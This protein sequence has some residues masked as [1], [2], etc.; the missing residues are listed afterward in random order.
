MYAHGGHAFF[1]YRI[2]LYGCPGN[3]SVIVFV[4]KGISKWLVNYL[5]T[6]ILFLLYT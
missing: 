2:V 5:E 3:K 6:I 4:V 1:Y